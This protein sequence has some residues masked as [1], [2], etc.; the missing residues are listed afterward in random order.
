MS[1]IKTEE[2]TSKDFFDKLYSIPNF[3][4]ENIKMQLADGEVTIGHITLATTENQFPQE[5]T[6]EAIYNESKKLGDFA[7]EAGFS[8]GAKWMRSKLTN[9]QT[10]KP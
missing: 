6:D 3:H 10:L 8:S 4:A 1:E 5:V 7:M 2:M 9:N